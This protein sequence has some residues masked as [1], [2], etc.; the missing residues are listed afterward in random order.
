MCSVAGV[1][2]TAVAGKMH[3]CGD[4]RLH[5]RHLHGSSDRTLL[6]HTRDDTAVDRHILVTPLFQKVWPLCWKS[7]KVC[8]KTWLDATTYLEVCG[9]IV[10]QIL[11]GLIGD[12]IGRRFG[13]IQDAVIMVIG[14]IMLTASWG[15]TLNGW[16]ICVDSHN[17]EHSLRRSFS[18]N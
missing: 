7:A 2:V 3:M 5:S 10:G 11:V 9:I 15:T 17:E 18:K 1:T 8:N 12:S 16:V 14:L 4:I 13:L 6:R